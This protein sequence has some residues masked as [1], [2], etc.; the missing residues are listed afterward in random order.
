MAIKKLTFLLLICLQG[1]ASGS[2]PKL[3]VEIFGCNKSE[4]LFPQLDTY[5]KNLSKEIS[6]HFLLICDNNNEEINSAE[7]R[8]KLDKYPF[9][10]VVFQECTSKAKAFNE[11]LK[12]Y[13]DSFDFLL[14]ADS[15]YL[16][17]ALG[18]D[19][20]IA[21]AMT[22]HFPD[23]DGVLHFH[24]QPNPTLNQTPVI[25]HKFLQRQGYL[26]YPAYNIS[27]YDLELTY[28]SRILG[29]EVMVHKELMQKTGSHCES[30]LDEVTFFQRQQNTFGLDETTLKEL[31]PK[32]WSILIC[33]LDE[34][35]ELFSHIYGKLTQQIKDHHL[36]NRVEV[37]YF[38][39]NRENSIGKKRNEL[40]QKSRGMYVN[41]IDDDDD[42]HDEYIKMLHEKITQKPDC[43]SLQGIIT[44]DGI[45]P[46]PFFHSVEYSTYFEDEKG[47]YRPPNHLN[48]MKRSVAS[49]FLF[50]NISYGEDTD[51]AMQVC[52]ASLLKTEEKI[53][54][55]YYFYN[56]I[57]AK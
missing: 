2:P 25:G 46:R 51:W 34:R 32:D 22:S 35:E 42:I 45:Y 52:R 54:T 49:Q 1:L 6:V 11:G 43:I 47:Y 50:P 5:H 20:E 48:V 9:T 18:Y 12:Y 17:L 28:V 4:Q 27:N 39:D 40:M 10:T 8:E 56:F 24:A 37:L 36:E 30:P 14:V 53:S 33:T 23:N 38:K 31:F 29:K 16:P 13:P 57:T 26:F 7:T 44:F 55:P 21:K 15:D 41:F 19:K 3:L